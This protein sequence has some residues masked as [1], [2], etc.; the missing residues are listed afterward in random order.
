M[1]NGR[2]QIWPIIAV[3]VSSFHISPKYVKMSIET[4]VSSLENDG[5]F[6]VEAELTVAS[7]VRNGKQIGLEC[8][9]TKSLQ[10][11]CQVLC[12]RRHGNL[13]SETQD[14]KGPENL[15]V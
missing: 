1:R 5:R 15:S 9:E 13:E 8:I 10:G 7:I 11:Q 3:K 6:S 4:T 14:V 2:A 12:L